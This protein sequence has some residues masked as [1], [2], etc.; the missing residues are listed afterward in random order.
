MDALPESGPVEDPWNERRFPHAPLETERIRPFLGNREILSCALLSGGACNSNY[1]IRLSTGEDYVVRLY[2]RGSPLLEQ[3]AMALVKKLLPVPEVLQAGEGWAVM[4]F[5]PGVQLR[6]APEAAASAARALAVV[7]TVGFPSAGELLPDGSVR[8]WPFRGLRGF[9][10]LCL[11]KPGVR[12]RLGLDAVHGIERLLER[13]DGRLSEIEAESRL[14]HG[15]F[16]PRNILV[17]EGEVSGILDWEFAH[18]GSPWEDVGN[19]LRHQAPG[20]LRAVEEGLREGGM[21][22]PPDWRRRADLA[23][24]SS[25]LEFLD[26]TLSEAW[27]ERCVARVRALLEPR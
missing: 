17:S 11:E 8:P 2:R 7:G 16:N 3:R 1:R 21:S 6:E 26:S 19:L 14:V 13:E 4:R 10:A 9:M 5:L 23:D 25:H 12:G 22:L 20:S 24:L 18:S 27:K 15:D